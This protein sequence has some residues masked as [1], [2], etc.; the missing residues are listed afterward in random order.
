MRTEFEFLIEKVQNRAYGSPDLHTYSP[1]RG[2]QFHG[3]HVL[4]DCPHLARRRLTRASQA[5][6]A[7]KGAKRFKLSM[8][9]IGRSLTR[10]PVRRHLR[11]NGHHGKVADVPITDRL[12]LGSVTSVEGPEKT[13]SMTIY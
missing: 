12:S 7:A 3:Y 13:T 10:R 2:C 6:R 9:H 5:R 11:Y 1:K 4:R 8:S